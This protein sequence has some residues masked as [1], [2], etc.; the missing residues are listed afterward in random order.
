M[1]TVSAPT[2]SLNRQLH[3]MFGLSTA[4]LALHALA[5]AFLFRWEVP[6]FIFGLFAFHTTLIWHMVVTGRLAAGL[7][8]FG[9]EQEPV[10]LVVAKMWVT[11]VLLAGFS[12]MLLHM[13]FNGHGPAARFP[14]VFNGAGVALI[15]VAI[16]I[17]LG[18][19][20]LARKHRPA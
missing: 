1:S 15:G 3:W 14:E 4:G 16:G 6:A 7:M 13:A 11:G 19:I 17:V 10:S 18:A 12:L 5:A 9:V 20:A 2:P 8:S